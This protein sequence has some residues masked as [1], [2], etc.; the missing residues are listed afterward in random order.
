M[1][2]KEEREQR[3]RNVICPHCAS[4]RVIYVSDG[5]FKCLGCGAEMKHTEVPDYEQKST[6]Q[7]IYELETR[8]DDLEERFDSLISS[9]KGSK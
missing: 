9:M 7:R 4:R 1:S 3:N 6:D 8:V 2:P 5:I